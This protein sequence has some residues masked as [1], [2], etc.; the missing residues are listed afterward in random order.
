M[1]RAV[2]VYRLALPHYTV[3]RPPQ[4]RSV[5]RAIDSLLIA[6][7]P[8]RRVALRGV[9]LVD[10]PALSRDALIARIIALGTDRYD[11]ERVGMHHD[12][13]A[14]FGV[15]LHAVSCT[16]TPHLDTMAEFVED[17]YA[18][19]LA[20]R[21]RSLRVDLLLVYDADRLREI[22]GIHHADETASCAFAF[23]DPDRKPDALLGIVSILA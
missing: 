15:D 7:F 11:P 16:V 4:Y 17:F 22:P 1:A 12:F 10:H 20:E 21:G 9:D 3:A 14:P 6:R 23:L 2:P 5:G 18:S 13:Y 19:A 8:G